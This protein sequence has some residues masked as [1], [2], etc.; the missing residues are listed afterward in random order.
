MTRCMID[1][2][3]ATQKALAA[4]R[5]RANRVEL[6]FT[7]AGTVIVTPNSKGG[8]TIMLPEEE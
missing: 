3:R 5:G 7:A 1:A 8:L 2:I 4:T 6:E